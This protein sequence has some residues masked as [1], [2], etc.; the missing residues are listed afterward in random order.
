MLRLSK[1]TDYATVILSYMAR[2]FINLHAAVEIA[3]A[4]DIALPTVAKILKLLVNAQI[5]T[6]AR[7]AKGGYLLA[8]P[9]EK[10]T[11]AVIIYALEGP[12]AI[13]ECSI[14]ADHC[15]QSNGCKIRANWGLINQTIYNALEAITLADMIV[16]VALPNEVHIPVASL[17]R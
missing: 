10:I 5:V 6:S 2:D 7:G 13:T 15:E 1:L 16:P 14:S 9:P 3:E 12:I 4:T 11:V 8:R 17:F